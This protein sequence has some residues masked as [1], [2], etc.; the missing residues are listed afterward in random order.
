MVTRTCQAK[1][2]FMN[3]FRLPGMKGPQPPGTY[4]LITDEE[5]LMGLS[6][7]AYRTVQA[8]LQFPAIGR[9][10]R[11]SRMVPV[12]LDDLDACI[13]ADRQA[14]ACDE[15]RMAEPVA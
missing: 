15:L 3:P 1:V 4:R 13:C 5:E 11:A 9:D 12:S 10:A 7:I 8:M 6:F 14:V 2:Q